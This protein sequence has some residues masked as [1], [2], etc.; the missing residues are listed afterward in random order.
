MLGFRNGCVRRALRDITM[1]TSVRPLPN[2]GNVPA[3]VS[4]AKASFMPPKKLAKPVPPVRTLDELLEE[5]RRLEQ[6]GRELMEQAKALASEVTE[7][8][9][10]SENGR[11]RRK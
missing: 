7:A 6:R 9:A 3:L 11:T 8:R 5:S 2:S 1:N 10:R 4:P